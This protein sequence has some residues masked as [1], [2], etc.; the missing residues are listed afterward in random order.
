MEF[1]DCAKGLDKGELRHLGAHKCESSSPAFWKALAW[2]C[3][4]LVP[5]EKRHHYKL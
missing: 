4:A 1:P 3:K 5:L 2:F